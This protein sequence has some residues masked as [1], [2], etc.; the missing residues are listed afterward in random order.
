MPLAHWRHV[1]DDARRYTTGDQRLPNQWQY[2]KK[3]GVDR[4]RDSLRPPFTPGATQK[5]DSAA[6]SI[7]FL[8]LGILRCGLSCTPCTTPPNHLRRGLHFLHKPRSPTPIPMVPR[9]SSVS[10]PYLAR[11][12][13]QNI[14]FLLGALTPPARII[15]LQS[16]AFQVLM[17]MHLHRILA[18]PTT[19]II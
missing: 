2:T 17:T 3:L 10:P 6:Q 15:S 11:R 13:G 1:H 19:Q 8:T 9:A 5:S 4:P 7:Y 12:L 16:A 18:Q 14:V